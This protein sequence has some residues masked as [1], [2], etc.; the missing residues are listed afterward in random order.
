MDGEDP[1]RRLGHR[2]RQLRQRKKLRPA[3]V[4]A[5]VACD[6]SYISHL[7]AGR[8]WPSLRVAQRLDQ[9]LDAGGDLVALWAE[10]D[11][12]RPRQPMPT[13][14]S[15]SM[16]SPPVPQT[17]YAPVWL[18]ML[19]PD[20]LDAWDAA[21]NGKE[22]ATD[23]FQ[24]YR[25]V[26]AHGL[27]AVRES[28]QLAIQLEGPAGGPLTREQLTQAIDHYALGYGAVPALLL[29]DE[30]RACRRLTAQLLRHQRDDAPQRELYR[31][32]GWLSALLGNLSFHLA[33]SVGAKLHLTL[34][35]QL[36]QRAGE[37][38]LLAWTRGA[39]SMVALW[40][41][42]DQHARELRSC[43][44]SRASASAATRCAC[45]PRPPTS[46]PRTRTAGRPAASGSTGPSSSCTP[47]RPTSPSTS[48]PTP[49]RTRRPPVPSRT[50]AP[51]GGPREC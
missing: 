15:T 48:Q 31:A 36:G 44:R 20:A 21:N 11:A 35:W 18:T 38:R 13:A 32:A 9:V 17:R 50:P 46:S 34:A 37:G 49:T 6:R 51:T 1:A 25:E 8:R 2:V 29:F 14:M 43:G 26:T 30:V 45:S 40:D 19:A 28:V 10:L 16:S 22:P 41:G 47:P 33:D 3:R 23:R 27:P 24:Y 12:R 4:A 7:E 42:D 5:A 39:Q